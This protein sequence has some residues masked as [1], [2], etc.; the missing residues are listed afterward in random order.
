MTMSKM[1]KQ[2][3]KEKMLL[4]YTSACKGEQVKA[5]NILKQMERAIDDE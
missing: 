1:A 3:M 5:H 2:Y 4:L